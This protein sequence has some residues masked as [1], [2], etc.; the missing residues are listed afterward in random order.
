MAKKI[1]TGL[2]VLIAV[3][4]LLFYVV[5]YDVPYSKNLSLIDPLLTPT[6]IWLMI[7]FL[8][9]ALLLTL[10]SVI[11]SIRKG[12]G[13]KVVNNIPL[14][15]IGWGVSIMLVVIMGLTLWL[16]DYVTMFILSSVILILIAF[17]MVI[18]STIKKA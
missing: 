7:A 18:V 2:I 1:K 8:G 14:T 12:N 15:K 5:G 17:I 6:V 4:F 9:V 10:V 3:V 13:H 11:I 16:T